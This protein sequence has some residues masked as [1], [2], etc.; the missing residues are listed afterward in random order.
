MAKIEIDILEISK[1]RWR[2]YVNQK[3]QIYDTN[4]LEQNTRMRRVG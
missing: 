4:I 1:I 3:I 2:R